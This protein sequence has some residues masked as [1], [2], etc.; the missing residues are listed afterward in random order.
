MWDKILTYDYSRLAFWF[1]IAAI[2]MLAAL[3]MP[4]M[5]YIWLKITSKKKNHFLGYKIK[6]ALT[7]N[8]AWEYANRVAGKSWLISGVFLILVD[9]VV[10]LMCRHGPVEEICAKALFMV[11]IELCLMV[12]LHFNLRRLVK[13]LFV[14]KNK[15]DQE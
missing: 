13:K 6:I 4:I 5:G 14:S 15:G 2:V 7:E 12:I 10:M 11:L 3:I 8:N 9:L 1:G